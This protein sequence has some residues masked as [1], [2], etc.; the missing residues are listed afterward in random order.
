MRLFILEEERNTAPPGMNRRSVM[1]AHWYVV[2]SQQ[3]FAPYTTNV[4]VRHDRL[5]Y[6]ACR[7]ERL[8]LP[9]LRCILLVSQ[10][11]MYVAFL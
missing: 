8:S 10:I 11:I 3:L 7:M 1:D 5:S 6:M 9:L 4:Y 2:M